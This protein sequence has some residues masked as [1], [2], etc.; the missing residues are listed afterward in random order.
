M[1]LGLGGGI[2]EAMPPLKAAEQVDLERY[3]GTWR[4]V[5]CLKGEE[6]E[7]MADAV[8]TY[9]AETWRKIGV[10]ASWREG[11]LA[12]SQQVAEDKAVLLDP[13]TNAQWR[14]KSGPLIGPSRVILAVSKDY[15]WAVVGVPSRRE[16]W[17]LSRSGHLPPAAKKRVIEVLGENGYDAKKFWSVAQPK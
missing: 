14:M 15:E 13:G 12:G 10:K 6:K 8:E 4:V 9:Q 17:V 7:K 11:S 5:A 3:M 1:V 16:G 2:A